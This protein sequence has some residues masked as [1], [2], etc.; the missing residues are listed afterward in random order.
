MKKKYFFVFIY[1][2]FFTYIS[3]AQMGISNPNA[4]GGTPHGP[5]WS[6]SEDNGFYKELSVSGSPYLQG[7]FS[8]SVLH[9]NNGIV[10]KTGARLNNNTNCFEIENDGKIYSVLNDKLNWVDF[11]GATYLVKQLG[12]EADENVLVKKILEDK[13]GGVFML[14]LSKLVEGQNVDAYQQSADPYYHEMNPIYF[15]ETNNKM[16]NLISLNNLYNAFPER[17]KELRTFTKKNKFKKDQL[18]DVLCLY[19]KVSK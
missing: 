7:D 6:W 16:I 17:K 18:D 5:E 1:L 2:L 10:L 9:F 3:N 4:L 15:I 8:Q 19:E 11:E 14:K 12:A 13:N